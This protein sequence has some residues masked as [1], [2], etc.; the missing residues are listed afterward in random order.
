VQKKILLKISLGVMLFS[1]TSCNTTS[2]SVIASTSEEVTSEEVIT[3]SMTNPE[4]FTALQE[5]PR[6]LASP[7]VILTA[8]GEYFDETA[9]ASTF[10]NMYEAIR[11]AGQN[12]NTKNKLQ[13]Q[14]ANF[15]QIFTYQ[16][17][18]LYFV[19]DGIDYVGTSSTS[20]CVAYID[21]HSNS[22]G[23]SGT[24]SEYKYLG[25]TD[26]PGSTDFEESELET[27]S[28]SYNYMFSDSGVTPDTIQNGF[29][30]ATCNVRLSEAT[31]KPSEDGDGWNAYIFI[32]LSAAITSDLGLIGSYNSSTDSVD[33]KMV[34]NCSSTQH[35]V[36]TSSV[37]DEAKFYVYHDKLV[38]SMSDYNATTK[39][40]SGADDLYFEAIGFSDGWMLNITNLTT[41][42]IFSFEDRHTDSEGNQLVENG[43]DNAMY[44]RALLAASYCPVVG[45]IWN[46][47]CGAALRNVVYDNVELTRYI[48]DNIESYRSEDAIR[49]EFYPETEAFNHGYAQGAD[50]ASFAYGEREENGT[51]KSGDT[52]AQ[53]DKFV[54]F[55]CYYDGLE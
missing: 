48:D 6:V 49:Y 20:D 3:Y 9:E 29:S 54:S 25:R 40:Y 18:S 28:G 33:W 34:R 2:T 12:S 36:G 24:A 22:Y 35:T 16:K 10:D 52:Y 39:E 19:F 14:D 11:T 43:A 4:V 31:Y 5:T 23:V 27:F 41:N 8:E 17:A 21:A 7:F 1:L 42:Q 26:M 46:A 47:R 44:F 55:S 50:N 53:G 32:N 51:Y 38:T 13:V 45:N 37:E 30:Y 15:L